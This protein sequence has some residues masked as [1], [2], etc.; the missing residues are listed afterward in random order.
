MNRVIE[1]NEL[2]FEEIIDRRF[3][4]AEAEKALAY[5]WDGKHLGKIVLELDGIH[6]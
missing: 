6:A 5:L 2:R 1:A 3:S 4:L